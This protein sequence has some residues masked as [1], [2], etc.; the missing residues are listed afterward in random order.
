MPTVLNARVINSERETNVLLTVV[1][2]ILRT[3]QTILANNVL[4]TVRSV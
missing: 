2:V 1:K 4:I 3:T